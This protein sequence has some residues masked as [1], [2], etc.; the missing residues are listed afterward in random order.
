MG[1]HQ[2]VAVREATTFVV[3]DGGGGGDF[4][5]TV[6]VV[7]VV[8]LDLFQPASSGSS[9]RSRRTSGPAGGRRTARVRKCLSKE[10]W[11][12]DEEG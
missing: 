10:E 7:L 4:R 9:R 3:D 11:K 2:P 12:G 8:G 1:S 6:V 5:M